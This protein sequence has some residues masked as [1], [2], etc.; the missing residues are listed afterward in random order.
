MNFNTYY[1]LFD[2]PEKECTVNTNNTE[3]IKM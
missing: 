1:K 3:F 2:Y